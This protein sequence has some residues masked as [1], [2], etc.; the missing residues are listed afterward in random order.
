MLEHKTEELAKTWLN[1]WYK[2]SPYLSEN[3]NENELD[4]KEGGIRD[5]ATTWLRSLFSAL[6]LVHDL[7]PDTC[8]NKLQ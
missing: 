4:T 7:R 8:C 1:P 2:H 3:K 6:S 5:I